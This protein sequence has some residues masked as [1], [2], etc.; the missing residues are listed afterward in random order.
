MSD[1]EKNIGPFDDSSKNNEPSKEYEQNLEE[2]TPPVQPSTEN[3][4]QEASPAPTPE[5]NKKTPEP[6]STNV[7]SV[8]D[9]DPFAE[10]EEEQFPDEV[11]AVSMKKKR[12]IVILIFAILVIAYF[13]SK[14]IPDSDKKKTK[15]AKTGV[16]KIKNKSEGVVP[17]NRGV[18]KLKG[19][20]KKSISQ[21][22]APPPPPPPPTFDP[23]SIYTAKNLDS[24]KTTITS[25]RSSENTGT[26]SSGGSGL[27]SLS[28]SSGSSTSF[29]ALPA[30]GGGVA[31]GSSKNRKTANE[32]MRK[33][34]TAPMFVGGSKAG[35][36]S[37]ENNSFTT[38]AVG[39]VNKEKKGLPFAT[40]FEAS[41]SFQ[42][43]TSYV[44]NLNKVILQGK[45]IDGVLE[46]ALNT[47]LPGKLRAIIS[48][49]VYAEAGRRV[50]I[51][52]GSRLIGTYDTEIK[53]GQGRVFIIWTRIIR[54]DGLDIIL[55]SNEDLI[56]TDLLGRTGVFG[57]LNNKFVEIFG[58]SILLTTM[59]VG[60]AIGASKVID[61][62]TATT[63]TS[64]S[65]TVTETGDVAST[66]ARDAILGLGDDFGGIME[67]YFNTQPA[68]SID[69]G[70]HIKIFVN[71]DIYFPHGYDKDVVTLS[72]SP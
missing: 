4:P 45:I 62:N 58:S 15:K 67:D 17:D 44:G 53:F 51:P 69:Q 39:V 22:T 24:S 31:G 46:T 27:P 19:A 37:S 52:K 3:Q 34:F 23:G 1:E 29:G 25:S 30:L 70:T 48:R 60:F 65:G 49:D 8:F 21:F 57:E 28:D 36:G 40:T 47:D 42:V 10:F 5:E 26:S 38:S 61:D 72:N 9:E 20:E 50:L 54:P 13:G 7:D 63:S 71:K 33:R 64:D 2:K 41:T 55:D 35:G 68:V 6:A 32:E 16:E 14:L 66:A 56:A 11:P 59:E 43:D 18:V 12:N